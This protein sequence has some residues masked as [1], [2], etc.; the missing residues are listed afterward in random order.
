M[1]ITEIIINVHDFKGG[2][3]DIFTSNFF[4][5]SKALILLV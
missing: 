3:K 4:M 5:T 1:K 2:I